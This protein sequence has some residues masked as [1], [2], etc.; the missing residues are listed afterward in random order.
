MEHGSC[1][2]IKVTVRSRI[3]ERPFG[4]ELVEL[5][6]RMIIRRSYLVQSRDP[7]E[8]FSLV[9]STLGENQSRLHCASPC[10]S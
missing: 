4:G 7:S 8:I 9:P 10:P 1:S 5:D 2:L 3:Q 6:V